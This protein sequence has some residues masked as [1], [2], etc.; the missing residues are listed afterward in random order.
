MMKSTFDRIHDLVLEKAQSAIFEEAD[1]LY[2]LALRSAQSA[3][4]RPHL[5]RRPTASRHETAT[6]FATS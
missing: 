6:T 4:C 5:G 2:A 1:G 3:T